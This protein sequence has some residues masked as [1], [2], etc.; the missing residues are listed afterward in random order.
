MDVLA[1][2]EALR[3]IEFLSE[4]GLSSEDFKRSL[5]A[6]VRSD[7]RVNSI[8]LLGRDGRPVLSAVEAGERAKILADGGETPEVDEEFL[9][10][11][12]SLPEGDVLISGFALSDWGR[13]TVVIHVGKGLF[14]GSGARAGYLVAEVDADDVVGGMRKVAGQSS[15]DLHIVAA[16]GRWIYDPR[17]NRPWAGVDEEAAGR[18]MTDEHPEVWRAMI[19]ADDGSYSGEDIWVFREHIPLES[20]ESGE[21]GVLE[22]DSE[23]EVT[24]VA[25]RPF[26]LVRKVDDGGMWSEVWSAVI[27]ILI[28]FVLALAI[29]IPSLIRKREALER[30]E[31][32]ARNLQEAVLRTRMAMETARISEWTID[33]NT[34][35]V[36]ADKRTASMMLLGAEN[37]IRTVEQWKERIH[38]N[39]RRKVMVNLESV[40]EQQKGTANVRH[41]MMRGDGSWGW[42]RFRGA[43]RRNEAE[44]K[45]YIIGAYIDLTDV[46]LKEAELHRLEMATRQSLSGITI[47]DN[48]GRVE[49]ANPAF[50]NRAERK[51]QSL[52]G[53]EIWELFPFPESEEVRQRETIRDLV[54]KGEEFSFTVSYHPRDEE[55]SWRR[56][57]GNP[58]L[59]EGGLP[60][61]YVVIES[62]ISK[63]KRTEAD[64]R[65]SET[66]LSESQKL[67]EIGSWEIDCEEDTLYWSDQTYRIFGVGPDYVPTVASSLRFY[68]AEDQEKIRV[69][70]EE[71]IESGKQFEGEFRLADGEADE[72]KWVFVKGMALRDAGVTEKVFGVVQDI[73]SRKDYEEALLRAKEEAEGLNDKLAAALDKAHQ[74]ERKAMEANEAK[75]AFLS[76]ISHEIRNP[77]NGVI[78]MTDLLWETE[79][80]GIQNDYV[81][82]IKNSGGSLLMLLDDILDYSKIEHGKIEFEQKEFSIINAVEESLLIFCTGMNDKGL[83]YGLWI[84][85]DVPES[86]VGDVTR[87][88]QILFNLIGNAVKFTEEGA[89]TV[90]VELR[91]RLPNDRCLL[92]FRVK[93]SGMGIPEERH[94]RIFQSFSQVDPSITRKFGGTGLGLAI[95]KELSQRM[96]GDI[97]FESATGEGAEFEVVLP[98]PAR[99]PKA[100]KRKGSGARESARGLGLFSLETRAR[101][102]T[103]GLKRHGVV[104]ERS[105][106]EEEFVGAVGEAPPDAWIFVDEE[107][108]GNGSIVEAFRRRP[109]TEGFRR[110]VVLTK[111]RREDGFGFDAVFLQRPGTR[112]RIGDLFAR[113][114]ENEETRKERETRPEKPVESSMKI[115]IAEDNAVNQKVIR[116]L[117]KRMGYGSEIAENGRLALERVKKGGVD[118]VL[119]DIQMPEMDG[120]EAAERILREVP[121]DDR[122]W[123]IALTAGATRDNRDEAIE[124]GMKGYLTKPVQPAD[125]QAELERAAEGIGEKV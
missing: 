40:W 112:K 11:L 95:S 54:Y 10:D 111:S 121:E 37:T 101:N 89:V 20:L 44:G 2:V 87:L 90:E 88:K 13:E 1:G 86:V 24:G 60:T 73:S 49:W 42:F 12:R 55:V 58:V 67:A 7:P 105:P 61:N 99:F 64:L 46:V 71:A 29:L 30:A 38:P 123:I 33:F 19:S 15:T 66:L 119:M 56:V 114:E 107:Y 3:R 22:P 59:D 70:L 79:L 62:D 120:I 109:E 52:S 6:A 32:S 82:T 4:T 91:E 113:P 117:L 92:V 5:R 106:T 77:L 125:L 102:F 35:K 72:P 108:A 48:E 103:T 96:G 78:G 47:L 43:V 69:H 27:P 17:T 76:M 115:L 85:D 116:L 122:P 26:Y 16:D 34:G 45:L 124:A 39:D 65:T 14:F 21:I 53:R 68:R 57:T 110:P 18:W 9:E 98:F 104:L 31:E 8:R 50:R 25:S 93:D 100:G 118:V 41:R 80:D 81:E 83:D 94:D 74:S 84:D 36:T 97:T 75:S 63:E 23:G 51:S 28:V